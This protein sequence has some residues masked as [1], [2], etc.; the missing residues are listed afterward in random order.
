M[1]AFLVSVIFAAA[2][3]VGADMVLNAQFQAPVS[4]A[5]ATE[6]SRVGDPGSNLIGN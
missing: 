2:L 4:S 3:A 1:K 6:G 5:F